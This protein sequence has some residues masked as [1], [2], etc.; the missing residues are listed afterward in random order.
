MAEWNNEQLQFMLQFVHHE[1]TL[2]GMP[3][4]EDPEQQSILLAQIFGLSPEYYR[5]HKQSFADLAWQAARE[6]LNDPMFR[7]RFDRLP[8]SSSEK[9]IGLGDSIT[10]DY[11]SWIEILRCL[12]VQGCPE[13]ELTVVNAGVSGDTTAQ[14][15]ARFL[16]VV[17]E[18]P[19]WIICMIGT[20]DARRHGLDPVKTLVSLDET[21]RNLAALHHFASAQT[22]AKWVWM[23]PASVIEEQIPLHWHLGQFQLS[24]KNEDLA[25]IADAIRQRPEPVVDL[26]A[27]FGTPP[28]PALLLLDGLHPSIEGQKHIVRALVEK[29]SA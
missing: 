5:A 28:D 20:N 16:G 2:A 12:F 13:K 1:K 27:I 8:F 15:I 22:Q 9:I 14:V 7:Q 18:N 24:W 4:I 6:L 3:G 29:L 26:Q 10:D 11:Q 21:V 25:A 19:D 17:N 23:T